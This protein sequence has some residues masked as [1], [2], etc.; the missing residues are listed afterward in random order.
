LRSNG[1]SFIYA[2]EINNTVVKYSGL[3]SAAIIN[4]EF[5]NFIIA[6]DMTKNEREHGRSLVSDAKQK[7]AQESAEW[8]YLVRGSPGV[9][10]ILKVR[11]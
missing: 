4:A 1:W 6:H 2:D 9:M 7:T 3:L 5:Q 11:K 8:R 10:K